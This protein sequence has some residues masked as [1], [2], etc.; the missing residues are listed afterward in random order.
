MRD[1]EARRDLSAMHQADP[2]D[3]P[4]LV[5]DRIML[6]RAEGDEVETARTLLRFPAAGLDRVGSSTALA[7]NRTFG[8]SAQEF[9]GANEPVP[10]RTATFA[11]RSAQ[12]C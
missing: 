7:L 8:V 5:A 3:R 12:P 6:T 4:S 10:T 2:Q 11:G 9:F 1:M